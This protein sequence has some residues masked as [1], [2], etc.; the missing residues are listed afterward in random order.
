MGS[1]PWA[2]VCLDLLGPLTVKAMVNK[3][4]CMKVWPLLLVCQVS[5]AMHLEVMHNY[6]T[7]TFLL[8]WRRFVV[9]HGCPVVVVSNRGSQ[10]T[11]KENEAN[12]DWKSIKESGVSSG[13]RWDF[14]P[15]G[16]QYRNG[17]CE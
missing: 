6:S 8:Q 17:L 10:L 1:P 12:M 15:A 9:I 7:V 2:A 3:R 11:S 13:T 14:V 4:S 16:C 5:S